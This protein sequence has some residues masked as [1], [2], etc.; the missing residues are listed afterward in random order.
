MN[1]KIDKYNP[2]FTIGYSDLSESGFL[3]LLKEHMIEAV[4]DVRSSPFSR[5]HPEFNY[6]RLKRTLITHRIQYVFLGKELGARRSEEECYVNGKVSYDLVFET[7]AFQDG[8]GHLIKG[9]DQMRVA[10]LCAEKDPLNCHRAILICR[11]VRNTIGPINHILN[12][13]QLENHSESERR[14]LTLLNLKNMDMFRNEADVL[15]DAYRK[16]AEKIAFSKEKTMGNERDY[17]NG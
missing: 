11:Y 3:S 15:E 2:L 17:D 10:L 9:I 16:Q 14:L 6:E 13:G 1:A 7:Q 8:I 4:A 12:N 5:I